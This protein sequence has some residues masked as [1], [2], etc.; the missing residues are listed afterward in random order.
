[1]GEEE[2]EEARDLLIEVARDH[3]DARTREWAVTRLANF[4][5][6]EVAEVLVS[7]LRESDAHEVQEAA[8]YGLSRQ[9]SDEATQAL[10]EFCIRRV[11]GETTP[12]D[13]RC[14][15]C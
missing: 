8:I 4:E 15:G 11:E 2:T 14:S 1:M 6:P 7:F 5:A 3:P 13:G 10:I 12:S 9:E